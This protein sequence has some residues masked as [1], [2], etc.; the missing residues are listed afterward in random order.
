MSFYWIFSIIDWFENPSLK[1]DGFCWTYRTHAD[2]APVLGRTKRTYRPVHHQMCQNKSFGANPKLCLARVDPTTIISIR[3]HL[4]YI[5]DVC[6]Y[7]VCSYLPIFFELLVCR[8]VFN[9]R[10]IKCRHTNGLIHIDFIP[11]S[12]LRP[13]FLFRVSS[14]KFKNT[15]STFTSVCPHFHVCLGHI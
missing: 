14:M 1:I 4:L 11:D 9:Y 2:E 15:I 7:L 12:D 6:L 5:P 10:L 3:Y 8:Y 13:L